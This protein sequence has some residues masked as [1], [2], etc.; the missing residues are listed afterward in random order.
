MYIDT[1]NLNWFQVCRHAHDEFGIVANSW[2]YSQIWSNKLFF[3]MVDFD[4]G[5]EVFTALNQNTA[6]VFIHFPAKG[7]P[8]KADYM[9]IHRIGFQAETIARWIAERTDVQVCFIG[10]LR[11]VASL[12]SRTPLLDSRVPTA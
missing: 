11:R 5:R 3:G 7:V 1:V 10:N 9:N 8:K 4:D 12:L 6:P 2:R